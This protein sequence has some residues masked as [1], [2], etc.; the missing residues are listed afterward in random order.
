VSLR[1][2]WE[3]IAYILIG[4][5]IAS[6]IGLVKE[7]FFNVPDFGMES[8]IC[9]PL[10]KAEAS[11]VNVA[12]GQVIPLPNATGPNPISARFINVG[13]KPLENL[14]VVLEFDAPERIDITDQSYTTKPERGFGS[15]DILEDG[16]NRRR[17]R[18]ALLNPGDELD[19]SAIGTRPVT[20]IAYAK[21][22]G[23]S[24]YQKKRPGCAW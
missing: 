1:A 11:L 20:I 19:Y 4:T 24:F 13:K 8:Q 12:T 21:F 14:D 18:I 7:R 5:V 2:H 22:P 16:P 23:L 9:A 3:K 17:I 6:A 15:V 10:A